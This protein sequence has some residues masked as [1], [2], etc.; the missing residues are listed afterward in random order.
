MAEGEKTQEIK[1]IVRI[2]NKDVKG[3]IPVAHA[4]TLVKG[5]SFMFANAVCAVLKLDRSQKSGLVSDSDLKRIEDC[6]KNPLKHGIP[7][8]LINRRRDRQTGEDLH[9]IS[10]DLDLTK[11]F[12]IRRI[13]KI[14]SYKGV[15]H[16]MG[17]KKVRGQKTKSTGRK[18]TT[19]GVQRKKKSGKK[20]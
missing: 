4:L 11:K 10:S 20:G 9:L 16:S 8:W 7:V 5:S 2:G 13:Q 3:D 17:S 12:D 18:G 19:L 15:R 14:K 1:G 6:L